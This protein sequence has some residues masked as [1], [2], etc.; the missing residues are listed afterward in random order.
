MNEAS[1]E[2]LIKFYPENCIQCYGCETAC[3]M[4]REL[5]HGV[6]YRRMVTLWKGAYPE[7][8]SAGLSLACLHCVEP[9]C[10]EACPE[11]AI[12]K[13]PEDGRVLVD[14]DRCIGCRACARA[15]PFGVPQFGKDK[16]MQK[17]DQCIGQVLCGT[18]PPCV[19][20]CTGKALV[21]EAVTR[22]EKKAC[23][24][25]MARALDNPSQTGS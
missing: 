9:A 17:C 4:W 25:F 1:Q 15:C 19:A 8:K 16:V 2:Y 12:S 14:A 13:R 18:A 22:K 7:V 6:R 5:P 10:L 24:A 11:K 21:L 20:T 23:E 3:K